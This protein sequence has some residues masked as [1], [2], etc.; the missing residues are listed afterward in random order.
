MS[1]NKSGYWISN[2]PTPAILLEYVKGKSLHDLSPKELNSSRLLKELQAMYDMLTKNRIVHRDLQLHKF[3]RVGQ[4]IVAL[5][6]E[7]SHFLPSDVINELKLKDLK[8][9]IAPKAA[10]KDTLVLY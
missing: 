10:V 6:F 4:K 7:F 3:F 9:L 5:N 8:D 2:R 1:H